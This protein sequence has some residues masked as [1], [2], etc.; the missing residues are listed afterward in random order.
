MNRSITLAAAVSALAITL[1]AASAS[2]AQP[3]ADVTLCYYLDIRHHL[4][5]NDMPDESEPGARLNYAKFVCHERTGTVKG[6]PVTPGYTAC[7]KAEGFVFAPASP[8]QIAARK[9]T[10]EK[11]QPPVVVIA[12]APPAI[13]ASIC[14]NAPSCARSRSWQDMTSP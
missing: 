2:A 3:R 7:M 9:K 11:A 1:G 10:I 8:A 6:G 5:V 12:P 14:P 13:E 4:M